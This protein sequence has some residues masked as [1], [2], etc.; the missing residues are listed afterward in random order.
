MTAKLTIWGIG[1]MAIVFIFTGSVTG[2]ILMPSEI[3]VQI[4]QEKETV[5]IKCD[6]CDY[7]IDYG[8]W[9][10]PGEKSPVEK[11]FVHFECD[12]CDYDADYGEIYQPAEK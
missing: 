3:D 2:E 12:P 6:P 7:N 8:N 1:I 4:V 10:H 11:E 5:Q 9:D